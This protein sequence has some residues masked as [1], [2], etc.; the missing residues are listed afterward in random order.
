[1]EVSRLRS[2]VEV[3]M[4]QAKRPRKPRKPTKLRYWEAE[5]YPDHGD[6]WIKFETGMILDA[7]DARYIARWLD[8]AADYLEA[9]RGGV[10]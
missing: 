9:R 1:M 2:V 10:K 8:R 6:E 7:K 5:V 3:F 4:T